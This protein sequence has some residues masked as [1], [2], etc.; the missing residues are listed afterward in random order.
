MSNTNTKA[1]LIQTDEA[2]TPSKMYCVRTTKCRL[3]IDAMIPMERGLQ[4][5]S[6]NGHS[7]AAK[8]LASQIPVT[9]AGENGEHTMTLNQWRDAYNR[10]AYGADW[11]GKMENAEKLMNY[12]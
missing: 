11:K 3:H 12:K 8:A 4:E 5:L 7:W 9:V 10:D 2:A 1:I 6:A